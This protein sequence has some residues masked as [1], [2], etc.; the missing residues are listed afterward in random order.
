MCRAV[1]VADISY[2]IAMTI[3]LH[4]TNQFSGSCWKFDKMSLRIDSCNT[5]HR[6]SAI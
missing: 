5:Y 4:F 2:N 1:C 3:F 6:V